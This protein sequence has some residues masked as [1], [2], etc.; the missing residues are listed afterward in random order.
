MA[1]I[2]KFK[3]SS[4]SQMYAHINRDKNTI[5]RYGN[6][7]IDTSK[8]HQN[9]DIHAGTMDTLRKRLESVSHTHRHDLVACCGVCITLPEELR[10]KSDLI[11]HGF[12][13]FCTSF[14][15]KKFGEEN[16]V[17]ATVHND[18]TTPHL[19]YGFVPVVKKQRKYRSKD[20]AGQTYIQERVCAKEVVTKEMLQSF[21]DELQNHI[22]MYMPGLDIKLCSPKELRLKDNKSIEQLKR[23]KY[24]K[25]QEEKEAKSKAQEILKQAEEEAQKKLS[26]VEWDIAVKR[27]QEEHRLS[28]LSRQAYEHELDTKRLL[29]ATER[30]HE[31]AVQKSKEL[32]EQTYMQARQD[33]YEDHAEEIKALEEENK[34]LRDYVSDIRKLLVRVW[35]YVA[36]FYNRGYATSEEAEDIKSISKTINEQDS[37]LK[38]TVSED[39]QVEREEPWWSKREIP[40]KRRSRSR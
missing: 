17:Y 38:K 8:T 26:K 23:E 35:N 20:K 39:T 6:T 36:K 7:D 15:D 1:H 34:K 30:E 22:S 37:L 3:L 11:K 9:Y 13:Q 27:Q 28:E 10:N 2:T 16:C 14:L 19:H 29:E 21:H 32:Y 4:M 18:E 31:R 24:K 40:Q 5:R 12:F 25:E 33:A